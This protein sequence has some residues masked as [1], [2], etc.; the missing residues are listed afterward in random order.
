L[1]NKEEGVYMVIV[2]VELSIHK[3]V[4]KTGWPRVLQPIDESIVYFN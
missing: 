3:L 1:D 2:S 4:S